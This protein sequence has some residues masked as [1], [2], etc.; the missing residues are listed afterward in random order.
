MGDVYAFVF[1]PVPT[2]EID[3]DKV[4][5]WL[6]AHSLQCG[7]VVAERRALVGDLDGPLE[8]DQVLELSALAGEAWTCYSHDGDSIEL[9]HARGGEVVLQREWDLD[10][11]AE[12]DDLSEQ[13]H[14]HIDAPVYWA[15]GRALGAELGFDDLHAELGG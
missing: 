3:R 8:M 6:R 13:V 2:T 12:P 9:A 11:E 4:L 5:E 15:T 14:A 1:S 10:L 7:E